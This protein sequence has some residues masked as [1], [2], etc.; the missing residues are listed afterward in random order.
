MVEVARE[1]LTSG[2]TPDLRAA[3]TD[4]AERLFSA[5]PAHPLM[6]RCL[7]GT[8]PVTVGAVMDLP[9]ISRLE[10]E[11]AGWLEVGQRLG[12]VRRD[13]R[14]SPARR[15]PRHDRPR[16]ASQL[17]AGRRQDR[18][19]LAGHGRDPR[20]GRDR[21]ATR[22]IAHLRAETGTFVGDQEYS[23]YCGGGWY[24]P[25]G[26]GGGAGW[27]GGGGGGAGW[28]GGGGGAEGGGW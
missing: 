28:L 23:A 2:R 19:S 21:A 5:M 7:T 15:R 14:R 16:P 17:R 22:L 26:G 18:L 24:P 4:L 12:L 6:L 8:E 1:A 10:D 25:D 20:S 27:L 3:L 11:I 9:S 13:P